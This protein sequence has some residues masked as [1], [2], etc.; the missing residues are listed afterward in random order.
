LQWLKTSSSSLSASGV[1]STL[2]SSSTSS[3]SAAFGGAVSGAVSD[4][5]SVGTQLS[6]DVNAL[7]R[8][9]ADAPL[10][11]ILGLKW[12]A[13]AN[14]GAGSLSPLGS[15]EEEGDEARLVRSQFLRLELLV[16]PFN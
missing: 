5:S 11:S 10:G 3:S 14:K 15:D 4:A 9:I 8:A 1:S 6:I 13:Q 12:D 16:R 7:G 2:S